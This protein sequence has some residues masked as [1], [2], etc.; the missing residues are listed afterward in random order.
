MKNRSNVEI[1][2]QILQVANGGNATKTQIMYRAFLAHKQLE[3]H[4][5]FLIEKG[6]LHYD[7]NT[8]TYG[9]TEKGLQFLKICNNIEDMIKYGHKG[10]EN[11]NSP[12][13]TAKRE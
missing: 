8:R 9:T 5:L 3:E 13:R 2:G 12:I 4:L 6:L 7:G 1:Q 10:N 11:N